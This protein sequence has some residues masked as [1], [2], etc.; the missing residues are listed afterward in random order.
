V[1]DPIQISV[2]I[3]ELDD[4]LKSIDTYGLYVRGFERETGL[5]Q[6][7]PEKEA[8]TVL[9]MRLTVASDLEPSWSLISERA[10]AQGQSRNLNWVIAS[11]WRRHASE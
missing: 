1:E 4:A 7:E 2:T 3:G 6:D 8:E 10:E 11:D 9:T 5:I